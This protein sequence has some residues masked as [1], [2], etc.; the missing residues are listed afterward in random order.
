[1]CIISTA[2]QARPKV[3][4]CSEPVRAQLM[5]SSV[6]VT[7]PLSTPGQ[8]AVTSFGGYLNPPNDEGTQEDRTL[9]P[10]GIV[11]RLMDLDEADGNWSADIISPSPIRSYT[12]AQLGQVF[13]LAFDDADN[14]NIYVTATSLYGLRRD[15]SGSDAS[16]A[17][18]QFGTEDNAGPGTI[19][20]IDGTTGEVSL[21]ANVER[22]GVPNSGPALGNIAF[23]P[24]SQQLFVSDRDT[25]LI[26][27]FDLDGQD[28][29]SST[30][31]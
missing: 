25:G 7:R 11:L 10:D 1:V 4:Q 28:R 31:A 9:D 2:Q 30:M 19:W 18:G 12:A 16:W 22:D 8:A 17:E 3:I 23:D 14:P 26:H 24:I 13:G 15:G 27:R 6:E 20:K 5:M 21:F 29:A